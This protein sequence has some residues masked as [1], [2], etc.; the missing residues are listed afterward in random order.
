MEVV[1]G[2]DAIQ[3]DRCDTWIHADSE[4][5]DLLPTDYK[6]LKRTKCVKIKFFCGTCEEELTSG[7]DPEDKIAQH[8][9]Q[10]ETLTCLVGQTLAMQKNQ[11]QQNE[12]ILKMLKDEKEL[13]TKNVDTNNTGVKKVEDKIKIH[14]NECIEEEKEKEEK[15]NNIIIYN[16][17]E[18]EGGDE[19]P[20]ED[21][22]QI[23]KIMKEINPEFREDGAEDSKMVIS[24]LGKKRSPTEKEPEVRPRP[25]RV[26][27]NNTE[28]KKTV[29]KNA[30]NLR[31]SKT[32]KKIGITS[33]KTRK[34]LNQDQM[35]RNE[36]KER[37]TKGEEVFIDYAEK[38]VILKI[39]RRPAQQKGTGATDVQQ[40]A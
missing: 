3:C 25:I 18:T 31:N 30:R 39:D 6:F 24:R 15:K 33:D 22:S 11:A 10:I 21:I 26:M 23:K 29:L 19:N 36:Y 17:E 34:E 9:S 2:T 32:F 28:E 5:S 12:E 8:S 13:K 7:D 16:I 1:E 38:K 14:V 27:F 40:D 4:C 37:T 35:L 20:Q